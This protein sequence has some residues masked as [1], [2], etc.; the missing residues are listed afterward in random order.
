M[1]RE[2]KQILSEG[3]KILPVNQNAFVSAPS[4][5]FFSMTDAADTIELTHCEYG[6]EVQQYFRSLFPHRQWVVFTDKVDTPLPI[7]V[8]MLLPTV[9]EPFYLL[10]T[11][12]MSAAPMRYP[13]SPEIPEGKES[14][15]ELC[16][17]L[18]GDWPFDAK[19]GRAISMEDEAAWPIRLL[20]ELGRF[21]HVHQLWMSYGFVL[22]NTENCEPF[23]KTTKLS[24]V[25]IVQ[26]EGALGEM[27]SADGTMV[28]LLMPYLVYKEEIELYDE[29]GPDELIE[30][31]LERNGESFLLDVRR[32]NVAVG[33]E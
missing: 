30:R 8:E 18:P 3:S 2:E 28:Q 33:D 16:M 9:E 7:H 27:Q 20:M 23:S 6:T 31:I 17:M 25:L 22:P 15:C 29:I 1:G 26:F 10:H 14:Y 19:G 12:G 5:R 32:P 24:G 11:I 4:R 13:S 21:P